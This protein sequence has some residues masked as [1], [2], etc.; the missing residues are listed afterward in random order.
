LGTPLRRYAAN[1]KLKTSNCEFG[2]DF[3]DHPPAD[4]HVVSDVMT[5]PASFDFRP[6]G[7]PSRPRVS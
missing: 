1:F 3:F 7:P 4:Y 5:S 6:I 2:L